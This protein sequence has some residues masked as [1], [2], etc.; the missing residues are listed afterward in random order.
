[1]QRVNTR[2]G[3]VIRTPKEL[4]DACQNQATI[5]FCDD[6]MGIHVFK[7][8]LDCLPFRTAM[9]ALQDGFLYLEH[10]GKS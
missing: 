4:F 8:D 5:L 1:M 7:I 6:V 10:G 2:L 9:C 3:K